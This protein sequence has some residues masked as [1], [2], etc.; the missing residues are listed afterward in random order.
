M[1]G[2]LHFLAYIPRFRFSF[3]PLVGI[4]RLSDAV[5][6]LYRLLDAPL[7]GFVLMV[8]NSLRFY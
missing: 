3:A 4:S 6:M 8:R 7:V 1:R 5:Q 2:L